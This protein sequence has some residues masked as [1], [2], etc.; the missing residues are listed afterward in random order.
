M[1]FS[2][3]LGLAF[4]V[5]CVGASLAA[6]GGGDSSTTKGTTSGTSQAGGGGGTAGGTNAGGSG[7]TAPQGGGSP[8]S[9]SSTGSGGEVYPAPHPAPH[10]VVDVGGPTQTAPKMVPIYF[11]DDDPTFVGQIDDFLSKVQSATYF[12]QAGAEYGV[13]AATIQP[14]IRLPED[15]PTTTDDTSIEAWLVSKI[16]AGDGVFPQPDTNTTYLVFYPSSTVI[17]DPGLGTSCQAYGGYHFNTYLHDGTP[18][19]YAVIP[20]C[21]STQG[22]S[23]MDLLTVTTSHEMLEAATDPIPSDATA[24]GRIDDQHL[25]VEYVLLAEIGDQC[26]FAPSDSATFPGL[27]YSVQRVY[28]NV[29]ALA[30]HDPC[31]PIPAG[32]VYF[33]AAPLPT[34]DVPIGNGE[35]MKGMIMNVGDSST[36]DVVLFS[37]APEDTWQVFPYDAEALYG[38]P[39]N[40]EFTL[41]HDH[42]QNGDKLKMSIHVL[43]KGQDGIEP[44]L[45]YS[46]ASNGEMHVWPGF[47]YTQ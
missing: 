32:R 46:I 38:R 45:M 39:P 8:T 40:L 42:G 19:V 5:S 41:D 4:F 15:A 28:S 2:R 25:Y 27:P 6:C 30:G 14:A 31:V 9:S 17:D 37:D 43:Q 1:N 13:G 47:V 35:S 18:V 29:S 20:R 22:I 33:A 7:G 10:T 16:E 36:L 12:A 44:Y 11:G 23:E 34:D 26:S 21:P 24:W 3:S